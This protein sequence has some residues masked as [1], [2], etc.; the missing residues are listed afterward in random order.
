MKWLL[1]FWAVPI[2]FLFS[3]YGLSYYDINFGYLFLSRDL[4][5]LVFAIYGEMLGVAPEAVPGLVF[6]AIVVDTILVFGLVWLRVKRKTIGSLLRGLF[7]RTQTG[8]V[9]QLS[10]E[11]RDADGRERDASLSSA[12]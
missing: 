2:V 4:H 1:I 5:D 11:R 12:P 6:K 10:R 3:W 8:E 9:D 7:G